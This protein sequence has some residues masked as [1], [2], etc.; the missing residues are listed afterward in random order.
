M[1]AVGSARR[2]AGVLLAP[3]KMGVSQLDA[4]ASWL[5]AQRLPGS[6]LP[7][8]LFQGDL[9]I[10]IARATDFPSLYRENKNNHPSERRPTMH[11]AKLRDIS[12]F[13]PG[14]RQHRAC[15]DIRLMNIDQ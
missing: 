7:L 14:Y 9:R 5:S 4:P 3:V 12:R 10:K 1:L 2:E 11:L 13:K 15:S 6:T 8:L